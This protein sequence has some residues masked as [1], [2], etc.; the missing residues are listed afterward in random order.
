VANSNGTYDIP[1]YTDRFSV[2]DRYNRPSMLA[3]VFVDRRYLP[4][5][6]LL[7]SLFVHGAILSGLLLLSSQV[8]A[9]QQYRAHVRVT[10]VNLKDPNYRL[11]LPILLSGH[12]ELAA[13][14]E[15]L[16]SRPERVAAPVP[17]VKGFS[18]PGPQPFISD[19]PKAT[20]SVQTVLQPA[21]QNLPTLPPP[22]L[23]P[24]VVR[25]ADAIPA[26]APFAT[27]RQPAASVE[28][29]VK[30]VPAPA[31]SQLPRVETPK[32]LL[33]SRSAPEFPEPAMPPVEKSLVP[34]ESNPVEASS[35]P[36]EPLLALSPMPAPSDERAKLPNGEARGRFAVSPEPNLAAPDTVPGFKTG[37]TS[38]TGTRT[39]P[40]TP[41]TSSGSTAPVKKT[42]PPASGG[43]N[44]GD[45]SPKAKSGNSADT[46][47]GI[48]I[49]GGT[50]GTN[51][52]SANII[53]IGGTP[54]PVQTSYGVTI[55]S[56]ETS[57]GGLPQFGVFSN[58]PIY[59]V[60]VD[61]R[62]TV[63]DVAPSW[64]F[65]YAVLK[66]SADHRTDD[67]G[68]TQQGLVLPFPIVKEEPTFSAELRRKYLGRRIIVFAIINADGKFEQV[69]IKDSPDPVLNE[70]VISAISKWIF[71]PAKLNGESVPVKALFGI[72]LT[73]DQAF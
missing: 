22:L 40:N 15:G 66:T 52:N 28:Q 48:T 60:Y 19:V 54:P 62:R 10:I 44:S 57:G 14:K 34:K 53:S 50:S 70:S 29:A 25:M 3:S 65:E 24:N 30:P 49:L 59:S 43:G 61:M 16:A 47:A 56:T 69:S 55:V 63:N 9:T 67:A 6:G 45:K 58:E 8:R 73:F 4:G 21:L 13:P 71:R 7:G 26:P 42:D 31:K 51:T 2:R 5:G 36:V 11:Y 23:L 12:A 37:T 35:K 41:G 1:G 46:F 72:P 64:T 17:T 18:Y 27:E 32:V 38:D 33:V 39:A 20:N 68:R